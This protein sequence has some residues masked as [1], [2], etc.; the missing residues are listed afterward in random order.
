[1]SRVAVVTGGASGIGYGIARQFSSQG[2]RVA[3]LDLQADMVEQASQALND[4]GGEAIGIA[5]DVRDRDAMESAFADIRRRLGPTDI[6]VTSAGVNA[7]TPF[8]EMSVS[9]W[10][11]VIDI[12][13]LGTF[14]AIQLALPDMVAANWGRIV[15]ISSVSAQLGAAGMANYVASKAGVIGLT[16]ALA[17]EFAPLGITVNTI[18]PSIVV[19]P[20]GLKSQSEGKL[21]YEAIARQTPV[22]RVGQPEDIAAA[23]AYL[24]SEQAG[25]ITGQQ[26]NVNGGWYV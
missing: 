5:V 9:E 18:P 1:M 3:L 4:A 22:R 20:M 2:D 21:D 25:F 13:L 12:N 6:L 24:C 10:Q 23:C 17:L 16:K 14:H 15:T 8:L 7:R 26:I 11:R 19:T